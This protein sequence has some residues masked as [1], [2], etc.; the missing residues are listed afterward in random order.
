M[1]PRYTKIVASQLILN[2]ILHTIIIVL[3]RTRASNIGL[4][5]YKMRLRIPDRKSPEAKYTYSYS[6]H[7]P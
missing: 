6:K 7:K 5:E 3:D 2:S 1:V 4:L